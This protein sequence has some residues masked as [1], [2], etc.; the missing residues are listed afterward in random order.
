MS[1]PALIS[2]LLSATEI[3]AACAPIMDKPSVNIVRIFIFVISI[4]EL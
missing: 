4:E 2:K 3:E 1:P